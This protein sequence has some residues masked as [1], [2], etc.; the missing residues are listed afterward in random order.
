[1]HASLTQIPDIG[2]F[3]SPL[4]LHLAAITIIYGQSCGFTTISYETGYEDVYSALHVTP[5]LRWQW[6]R[7]DAAGGVHPITIEL[8][9][10]VFKRRPPVSDR[11]KSTSVFM[12]EEDWE[13]DVSRRDP[14][15]AQF[16]RFPTGLFLPGPA[17]PNQQQLASV[18]QDGSNSSKSASPVGQPA[19]PNSLP[20]NVSQTNGHPSP[21]AAISA[22]AMPGTNSSY[23]KTE[24]I[25]FNSIFAQMPHHAYGA[26]NFQPEPEIQELFMQEEKDPMATLGDGYKVGFN[27]K[28]MEQLQH[29]VCIGVSS[30]HDL[31]TVFFFC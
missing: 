1:M 25:D 7:K 12:P 19:I 4:P 5:A 11:P 13:D 29:M 27:I 9:N 26:I 17:W 2:F 24:E 10:R 31:L 22:P 6:G 8:A 14:R 23:L 21:N 28:M 16:Y 15:V 20:G 3:V 18:H 30:R